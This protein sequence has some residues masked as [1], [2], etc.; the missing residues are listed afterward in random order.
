MLNL[1]SGLCSKCDEAKQA[2]NKVLR[3]PLANSSHTLYSLYIGP[4]QQ[5]QFN[6]NKPP[7]DSEELFMANHDRWHFVN[8]Q[9][10]C[11]TSTIKT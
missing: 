5:D 11:G 9:W 7:H 1:L 4:V 3:I 2:V 10:K 6:S 8:G